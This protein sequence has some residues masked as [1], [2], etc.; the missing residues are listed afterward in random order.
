[1][2]NTKNY[3]LEQGEEG[4][5]LTFPQVPSSLPNKD[6]YIVEF[7]V[8]ST[9]PTLSPP[10]VTFQ[11]TNPTYIINKSKNFSPIVNLKIK[12]NH[13]FE[14]QVLLQ[15]IVKDQFNN[16]LYNDYIM[17]VCSPVSTFTF[18]GTIVQPN[19]T[20]GI[21]P[22]GGSILRMQEASVVNSLLT[23]MVVTGP[24][25]PDN[26]V[27]TIRSFIE[28]RP[29]DIELSKNL[30]FIDQR[31]SGNYTFTRSLICANSEQL[32]IKQNQSAY[33]TLD[34][35]N[36][37]TYSYDEQIVAKFIREDTSDDTIQIILPLKNVSVLINRDLSARI[38][39][40]TDIYGVGRVIS[41][42]VCLNTF[43]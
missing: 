39:S 14:T 22:N 24:G 38:P 10:V 32:S 43:S 8:S 26:E 17:I 40:I 20:D 3:S 29:Q 15:V 37:W 13:N 7:K 28:G 11:P 16:I 33:I 25:I 12:A 1:M 2:I 35:S 4:I 5:L 23:G 27:V 9:L 36:N 18:K 21:G 19:T 6:I 34:K 42:T 31:F 41:N 30:G